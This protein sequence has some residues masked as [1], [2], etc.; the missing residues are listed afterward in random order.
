MVLERDWKHSSGFPCSK[1]IGAVVECTSVDSPVR[2]STLLVRWTC[3]IAARGLV[4]ADYA[5]LRLHVAA[6]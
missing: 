5:F 1:Q 6:L 4:T 2:P 3:G